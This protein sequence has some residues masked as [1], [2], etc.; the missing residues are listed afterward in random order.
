MRAGLA[1]ITRESC[2]FRFETSTVSKPTR[3]LARSHP[4]EPLLDR[5]AEAARA[6]LRDPRTVDPLLVP[7][8]ELP[9]TVGQL[10]RQLWVESVRDRESLDERIVRKARGRVR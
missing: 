1:Q 8:R 10:A 5:P 9:L 2:P 6:E 4:D 3:P 7:P